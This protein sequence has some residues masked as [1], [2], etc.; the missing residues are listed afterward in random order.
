MRSSSF[1]N[2]ATAATVTVPG[3]VTGGLTNG[4]CVVDY[5]YIISAI[6][7]AGALFFDFSSDKIYPI[8]N[9]ANKRPA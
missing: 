9:F 1:E 7:Y 3:T 4:V 5:N 8:A 2:R 6:Q